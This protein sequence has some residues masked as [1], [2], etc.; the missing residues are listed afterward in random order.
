MRERGFTLI[1][2]MIVIAIIAIIAAIAIPSLLGARRATNETAAIQNLKALQTCQEIYR[3][4]IYDGGTVKKYAQVIKGDG[5]TN[6]PVGYGLY[7]GRVVSGAFSGTA[8]TGALNDVALANAEG[9]P[10]GGTTNIGVFGVGVAQAA[11]AGYVFQAFVGTAAST[12]AYLSGTNM[13]GGYGYGAVPLTYGTTGTQQF[14]TDASGTVFSKDTTNNTAY[15]AYVNDSTW[16]S[17]D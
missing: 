5:A 17:V 7:Q 13:T 4:Q 14:M 6:G 1:E 15:G 11:K 9:N 2:L 10:T 12:N 3:K 16:V 8:T